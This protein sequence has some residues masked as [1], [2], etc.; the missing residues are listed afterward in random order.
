MH[1]RACLHTQVP[2]NS[3]VV[4]TAALRSTILSR[5]DNDL[6]SESADLKWKPAIHKRTKNKKKG[7]KKTKKTKARDHTRECLVYQMNFLGIFLWIS[8]VFSEVS[9]MCSRRLLGK[10]VMVKRS[11]QRKLRRS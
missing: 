10:Y 9:S 7:A 5:E 8:D 6:L 3:I 1:T 4:N 11:W 2:S